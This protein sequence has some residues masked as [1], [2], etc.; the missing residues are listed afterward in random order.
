MWAAESAE[1]GRDSQGVLF[2]TSET[3]TN[4]R[5]LHVSERNLIV[6]LHYEPS[7]TLRFLENYQM[8]N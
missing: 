6:R 1:P 5:H 4:K 7:R 3:P 2:S 8:E